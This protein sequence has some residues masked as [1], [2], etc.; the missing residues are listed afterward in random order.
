MCLIVCLVGVGCRC[1]WGKWSVFVGVFVGVDVGL[2]VIAND[3]WVWV[4]V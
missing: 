4:Q 1:E 2:V 3:S